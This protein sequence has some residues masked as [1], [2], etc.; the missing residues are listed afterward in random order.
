MKNIK[1]LIIF[2][3][4]T[5][6][7]MAQEQ[8][9]YL[10]L[11]DSYTIGEA[12]DSDST[13][14][15]LLVTKL[16][17]KGIDLKLEKIVATTGWTT[18][19]LISAI[20]KDKELANNT[21]D[22]V[23]LLI[24]VNNQYRGYGIKQYEEE[25]EF[26][27]KKAI[28]LAGKKAENVFVV[29]IPDYGVTPFVKKNNKNAELIGKELKLYN[30]IAQNISND[31]GVMFFDITPISL[32]AVWDKTYVAKDELHPS[33]KMYEEWAEYIESSVYLMLK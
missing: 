15:Q 3:F 9:S 21:Y 24:G 16:N 17:Q 31:Y 23:S 6:N 12:V 1:F 32:K 25:F 14:S 18:D 26:L 30:Q 5:V 8:I 2:L 4:A 11:G 27:L 10:A 7:L 29:S 33:A 20:E 13:W 22:V 19:E 28:Q